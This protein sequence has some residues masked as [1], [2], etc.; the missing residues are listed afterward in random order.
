M[1]RM[2]NMLWAYNIYV[3]SPSARPT[4]SDQHATS[5]PI[6]AGQ[7]CVYVKEIARWVF[8]TVYDPNGITYEDAAKAL[9]KIRSSVPPITS[10]N[11]NFLA[12]T[13]LFI[14]KTEVTD[15]ICKR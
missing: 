14:S 2:A 4:W 5:P 12:P 10:R 7:L 8:T 11:V 15:G 13:V 1:H 3:G 9:R 6:T